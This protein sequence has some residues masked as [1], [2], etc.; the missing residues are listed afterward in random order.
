MV[1]ERRRRREVEKDGLPLTQMLN[2]MLIIKRSLIGDLY[3]TLSHINIIL[4]KLYD[5]ILK[6]E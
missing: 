2:R 6:F 3:I 4:I 5:L 1:V